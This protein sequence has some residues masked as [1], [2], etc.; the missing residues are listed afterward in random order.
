MNRYSKLRFV[1][2]LI[3]CLWGFQFFKIGFSLIGLNSTLLPY[4]QRGM[5]QRMSQLEI[6]YKKNGLK[7]GVRE[8][9]FEREFGVLK[10]D[11]DNFKEGVAQG[12]NYFLEAAVVILC[13]LLC[14]LFWINTYLVLRKSTHFEKLMKTALFTVW[15]FVG[16]FYVYMLNQISFVFS[17]TERIMRLVEMLAGSKEM[18]VV[19][20]GRML[21]NF[22]VSPEGILFPVLFLLFFWGIPF[23]VYVWLKKRERLL[24]SST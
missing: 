15:G 6:E 24:F 13:Y 17:S 2:A 7:D 14:F 23:A 11:M 21:K 10:T 1:L 18:P 5:D 3:L 4:I 16:S 12:K 19:E 9:D 8:E 22:L 20:S